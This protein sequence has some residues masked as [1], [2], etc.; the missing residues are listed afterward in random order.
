MKA[1]AARHPLLSYF[2]LA[3]A[4]TWV[5]VVPALLSRR[6]YIGL[7]IPEAVEAIGA[8]GPFAAAMLIARVAS[9][10]EGPARILRSVARWRVGT[11]WLLFCVLS[12]VALLA[13]ALG[14]T[15]VVDGT[16]SRRS[17]GLVELMTLAGLVDLILIGGICQGLGEEPGWRGFA[18]PRLRQRFGPL[19]ATLALWPVWLCWHLPAFLSRPEFGM[20][21]WIGFSVGILSAAVWLTLIWDHTNSILMAIIW[22]ALINIMRGIAL[23]FSM[24]AFLAISNAVLI[25]ALLVVIWWLVR[26]PGPANEPAAS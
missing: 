4:M 22:H 21:Q 24:T 6:G 9:G 1:F 19:L 25:G 14:I 15:A 17:E 18:L 8:F 2:L 11:G 16:L 26:R 12:P 10:P 5:V 7:H 23:A 13:V 3:Y 20:A